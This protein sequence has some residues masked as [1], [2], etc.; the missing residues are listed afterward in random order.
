MHK[1]DVFIADE[2]HSVPAE[3]FEA[4]CMGVAAK[5]PY[6]FFFSATQLRT[7]GS[8]M[9]LKGVTG[10]VVYKKTFKELVNEGYLAKPVFRMFRVNSNGN[11]NRQDVNQETRKQLF[12]NPNVVKLA[13]DIADKSVQVAN[14]KTLIIIDELVQHELLSNY[15][16]TK[17]EFICGST[18]QA[19]RAEIIKEFNEKNNDDY[20]NVSF[21]V[22]IKFR[23]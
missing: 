13:A 15:L 22:N 3:T 18:P 20:H 14:R 6:R 21:I 12:E 10:P 5:A 7:D 1:T 4:V 2:S 9:I 16:K 23:S 19:K 8:E 11:T 17:H